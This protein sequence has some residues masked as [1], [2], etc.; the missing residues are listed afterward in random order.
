MATGSELL[1]GWQLYKDVEAKAGATGSSL[2]TP[3]KQTIQSPTNF[4]VSS[5]SA[6][7]EEY[8]LLR[9]IASLSMSADSERLVTASSG[10]GQKVVKVLGLD[11]SQ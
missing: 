3:K 5:R 1:G 9:E 4:P 6:R 7:A 10:D 11:G 2:V 8:F